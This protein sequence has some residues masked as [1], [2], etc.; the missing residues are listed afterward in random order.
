MAG[1]DRLKQ[2]SSSPERDDEFCN[3]SIA[4]LWALETGPLSGIDL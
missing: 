2:K 3:K 4:G 1:I